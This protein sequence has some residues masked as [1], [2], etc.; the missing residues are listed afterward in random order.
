SVRNPSIPAVRHFVLLRSLGDQAD[1]ATGADEGARIHALLGAAAS[2][3][4]NR[5]IDCGLAPG[6]SYHAFLESK[7]PP[8]IETRRRGQRQQH[9]A[10]REA[11]RSVDRRES[12]REAKLPQSRND[13]RRDPIGA[14]D[15]SLPLGTK[16]AAIQ[17]PHARPTR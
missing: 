9:P 13:L 16:P 3:N 10:L 7:L 1:T 15:C 17:R 4:S 2:S 11:L 8:W 5:S 12:S 14:P 6:S